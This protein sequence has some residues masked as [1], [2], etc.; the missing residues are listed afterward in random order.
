MQLLWG[1][2]IGGLN[3]FKFHLARIIGHYATACPRTIQDVRHQANMA[4][5]AY[6]EAKRK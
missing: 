1:R 5:N 2:I 4:L 6:N 3:C